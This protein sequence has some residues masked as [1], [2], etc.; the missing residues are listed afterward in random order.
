MVIVSDNDVSDSIM[1]PSYESEL[2]QRGSC[3]EVKAIQQEQEVD[4]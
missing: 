1:I 2:N 4:E 3:E